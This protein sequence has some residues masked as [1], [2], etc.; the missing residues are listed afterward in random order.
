MCTS[1]GELRMFLTF[2]VTL[3]NPFGCY[4]TCLL[5]HQVFVGLLYINRKKK[6]LTKERP[7]SVD[8]SYHLT[9]M[10]NT[11]PAVA[12]RCVFLSKIFVFQ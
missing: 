2:H 8:D 12:R 1:T 11:S 10:I 3:P 5:H 6:S 4:C 7:E 9:I